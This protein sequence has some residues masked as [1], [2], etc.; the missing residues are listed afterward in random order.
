ML[1]SREQNRRRRRLRYALPVALGPVAVALMGVGARDVQAR[2]HALEALPVDTVPKP[3]TR[4]LGRPLFSP[5]YLSRA[6]AVKLRQ[7]LEAI[8]IDRDPLGEEL[9]AAS[10]YARRYSISTDLATTI[11]E[12]ARAEGV[13]PDLAFRLVRVES[14]FKPN[15]RGPGGSLGLTQL[16]PSTAR[17]VDRSLRTE[18][19]IL[20]PRT[21]LEVGFRYLRQMIVRYEGNVKLGL[22]AYNRGEGAVDRALRNGRDPENG[23]S[24]L[25]LGI[26]GIRYSGKGLLPVSK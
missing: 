20:E 2:P 14:V 15:A 16:M 26:G 5:D 23:Y 25:V 4:L 6:L 1:P 21:N 8:P 22:L 9:R 7:R 12:S 11:I 19:Q 17:A 13:D 10:T 24:E 3:P 18:A